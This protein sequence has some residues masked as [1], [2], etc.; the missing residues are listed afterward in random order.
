MTKNNNK[1]YLGDGAYAEWDGHAVI[2]TAENGIETT[3]TIYLEPDA[4]K[5]LR[6]W[7]ETLADTIGLP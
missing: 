4:F 2:L 1:T 6:E 7:Y 3:D 5:T